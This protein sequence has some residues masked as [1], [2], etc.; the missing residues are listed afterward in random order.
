MDKGGN[1]PVIIN[2]HDQGG[3]QYGH[4]LQESY[5]CCGIA[6]AIIFFPIGLACCLTMKKKQCLKCGAQF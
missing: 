1:S 6:L 4:A 3:C 2:S 5:T